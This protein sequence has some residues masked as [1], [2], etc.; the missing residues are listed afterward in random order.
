MDVVVELI[1]VKCRLL[2]ADLIKLCILRTKQISIVLLKQSD[3]TMLI[4]RFCCS[5]LLFTESSIDSYAGKSF[6]GL[7]D[8]LTNIQNGYDVTAQWE[9]V[10]KHFSVIL[11]TLQSAASVLRDVSNFVVDF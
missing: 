7:A 1:K 5:H 10:Q 2:F 8:A 9:I 6:P 4:M 3:K 11:Y